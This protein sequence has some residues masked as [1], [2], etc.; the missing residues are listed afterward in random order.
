M[1]DMHYS[2]RGPSRMAPQRPR[3]G[4]I[5]SAAV[6]PVLVG[7][8][9]AIA[10]ALALDVLPD[11][12]ATRDACERRFCE[13]VLDRKISGP[14]LA[15]NMVKTWDRDK[16]RKNGKKKA[17]TWGFGDARCQMAINMTRQEIVPAL[18]ETSY[19]LQFPKQTVA[20]KIEDSDKKLTDLTVEASPKIKF[21]DGKA[22]KVW[23]NVTDVNG[24]GMVT[25]LVWTVSKLADGLGMFHKDTLK[26]INK[27]IHEKCIEEYGPGAETRPKAKDKNKAKDKSKTEIKAEVN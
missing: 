3:V 20:C 11:E 5:A 17:L 21:K 4:T 13:I 24:E 2:S 9:A 22:H 26:E 10:P 27:Y 6:V 1:I 18:V 25:G 7:L 14:P 23:I 8:W 12:K 15:C 19:T 16:I